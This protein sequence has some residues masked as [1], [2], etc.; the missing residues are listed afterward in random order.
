MTPSPPFIPSSP[1]TPGTPPRTEV[2]LAHTDGF[3]DASAGIGGPP[4]TG[5]TGGGV[6]DATATP[7]GPVPDASTAFDALAGAP[8]KV[9]TIRLQGL[10]RTRRAIVE[11]ELENL[12]SAESVGAVREL[13]LADWAVLNKLGVFKTVELAM[14][15]CDPVRRRRE[16]RLG[17]ERFG[18]VEGGCRDKSTPRLALRRAW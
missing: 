6:T 13:L 1:D 16:R 17:E 7:P 10:H 15:E 4:T 9:A 8:L 18:E 14:E 3:D 11:R 12:G 2:P 5:P